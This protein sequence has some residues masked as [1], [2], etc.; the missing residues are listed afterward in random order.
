MTVIWIV[1]WPFS[2]HFWFEPHGRSYGNVLFFCIFFLSLGLPIGQLGMFVQ[3]VSADRRQDCILNKFKQLEP[4]SSNNRSSVKTDLFAGDSE[5]FIW[6]QCLCWAWCCSPV[7]L[8]PPLLM[9]QQSFDVFRSWR[10]V[11]LFESFLFHLSWNKIHY[12]V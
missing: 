10:E 1:E 8:L 3:P 4:C 12:Q 7:G 9:K 11:V 6:Q 5:V 2:W